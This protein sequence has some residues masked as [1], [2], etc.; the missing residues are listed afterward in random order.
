MRQKTALKQIDRLLG[1]PNF[2]ARDAARLGMPA[3][4][5][6][7]YVRRGDLERVA[8][9]VYRSI[10]APTTTDFRW[11]DLVTA[12]QAIK[13]GVVCLTSALALYDITE[14]IPRQHWIAIKNTTRH[15]CGSD[16]R[17]VR[18][19]DM[20]LGR[21]RLDVGGISVPIFDRERTIVDSFRRLGRET[22]IK[23]L[24]FAL[25][26]RGRGQKL[27]LRKLGHYAN[28][29]RFDIQPY[30]LALTID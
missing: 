19:S 9:G 7:Y 24:K 21:T 29:L 13:D 28:R 25:E 8:H 3:A 6:A 20:S 5:L 17:V 10:Q 16:V 18:M 23:A 2:T 30:V 12:L 14:E 15:R 1:A 22:A 11:E 26:K 4:N 27:D